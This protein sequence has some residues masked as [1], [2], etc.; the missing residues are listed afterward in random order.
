MI[1]EDWH[2]GSHISRV[3]NPDYWGR[4]ERISKYKVPY[5][6]RIVGAIIPDEA[7]RIAALRT[8]RIDYLGPIGSTQIRSLNK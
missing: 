2:Q 5:I 1:R 8:G 4:D 7:T 6:D 3:K